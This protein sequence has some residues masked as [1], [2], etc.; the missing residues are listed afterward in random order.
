MAIFLVIFISL[1]ANFA[2]A[3][4][5]EI[6]RQKIEK[7]TGANHR[8]TFGMVEITSSDADAIQAAKTIAKAE[9]AKTFKLKIKTA[10]SQEISYQ[11]TR[12]K[13]DSSKINTSTIIHE[14]T[15]EVD[16]TGID[17]ANFEINHEK[18]MVQVAAV[19]NLA[20][21][22]KYLINKAQSILAS[23]DQSKGKSY[24]STIETLKTLRRKLHTISEAE[25][26]ED[27]LLTFSDKTLQIAK[28][29]NDEFEHV[30][31]CRGKFYISTSGISPSIRSYVNGVLTASG[32]SVES[33]KK[34]MPSSTPPMKI[35]INKELSPPET[36]FNRINILGKVEISLDMENGQEAKWQSPTIRQADV[37]LESTKMKLDIRL[38]D[39]V[40]KGVLALLEEN[41]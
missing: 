39:E 35:S 11:Q 13:A 31:S 12:N 20:E 27:I 4:T 3:D 40:S 24:C 9:M 14:S 32:Y 25:K 6:W 16:L 10:S 26:Y 33:D 38:N 7:S 19:L 28:L 17:L 41:L 18:K 21:F 22:E 30:K 1:F 2:C 5:S 15:E 34:R 8:V 23:V 29:K 37:D 36:K